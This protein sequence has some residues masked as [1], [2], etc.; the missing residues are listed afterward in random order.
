MN[1]SAFRIL[2]VERNRHV[3]EFLRREFSEDGYLVTT[4]KDGDEA[5]RG[6]SNGEPPHAVILDSDVPDGGELAKG[7]AGRA[8]RPPVIL[9]CFPEEDRSGRKAFGETA[10]TVEKSGDPAPLK[11][12]TREV[13][14][15]RYPDKA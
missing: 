13:L 15:G 5:M 12:A 11:A 7:L 10:A 9:H 1:F 3:R 8:D 2:I 6:L 14:K 4:A